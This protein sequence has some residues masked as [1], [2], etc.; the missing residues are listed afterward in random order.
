MTLP[1][2][3]L[4]NHIFNVFM[5][6]PVYTDRRHNVL[7]L[8]VRASIRPSVRPSVRPSIRPSVR[9]FVSKLVNTILWKQVNQIC[10]KLAQLKWC[11]G[12]GNETINFWD[13]EIKV[14]VTRRRS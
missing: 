2:I 6:P 12:Q 14:S 11:I 8:S 4:Q 3:G 13:Q 7:D 1:V 5:P 9:P 10:W